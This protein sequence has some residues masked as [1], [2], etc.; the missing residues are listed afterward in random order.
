[1]R[2]RGVQSETPAGEGVTQEEPLIEVWR[3]HRHHSAR[4]DRRP[5]QKGQAASNGPERSARANAPAANREANERPRHGRNE[6]R[7][8]GHAAEGKAQP[9]RR[10]DE[11][12][13]HNNRDTAKDEAR[14][15]G[16]Q[17]AGRDRQAS[18]P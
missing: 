6:R 1:M 4:R 5:Q 2:G 15:D 12:R 17:G 16:R 11:K 9:N 3:P 18:P 8:R 10:H 13:H 14:K 7:A